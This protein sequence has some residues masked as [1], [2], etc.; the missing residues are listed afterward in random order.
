MK[1]LHRILGIVLL[2]PLLLWATTGAVFLV[3]P[4]YDAAYEQIAPKLYPIDEPLHVEGMSRWSDI[5]IIKT[6]LGSHLLVLDNNHWKHLDPATLEPRQNPTPDDVLALV[7]DALQGR[8][9]RYGTINRVEGLAAY[10]DTGVVVTLDWD[11]LS[12]RQTG[13]DTSII[14]M[15]YRIHYLQWTPSP[16]L[17]QLLGVLGLTLLF[18]LT[19]LGLFLFMRGKGGDSAVAVDREL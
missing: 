17:N 4:G 5:R 8:S 1:N 18:T 2:L 16:A 19:V 14:D 9:E 10:T 3:K 6:I 12:L 11:T 7:A 13:P 15:L